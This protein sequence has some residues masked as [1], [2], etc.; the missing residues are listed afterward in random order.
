M[1]DMAVRRQRQ[2]YGSLL[3]KLEQSVNVEDWWRTV[4]SALA[5]VP[6]ATI[7]GVA[8]NA[9]MAPRFTKALDVGVLADHLGQAEVALEAAGWSRS[10]R[11]A[12]SSATPASQI[13][14]AG[15]ARD[16]PVKDHYR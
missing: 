9:Y 7:G 11:W 14:A 6:H 15:S 2:G 8:T 5:G 1:I 4:E 10:A 3:S 16:D 12:S 13:A